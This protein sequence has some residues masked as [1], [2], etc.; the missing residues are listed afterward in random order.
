MSSLVIG[1]IVFVA[2]LFGA[3]FGMWLRRRLP[4]HH[5][6]DQTRDT[7]NLGIGLVATMSAIILGLMI[8]STKNTFDSMDSSVREAAVDILTLDRT[9]ARYGAETSVLRHGLKSAVERHLAMIGS[10][11]AYEVTIHDPT[12]LAREI[13]E[14]SNAIGM[15]T[16]SDPI[17]VA[18]Q[19]RAQDLSEDLMESRW[20]ASTGSGS[21]VPAPFL[22]V[23]IFW[24]TITLA[25]F[26]L[27]APRNQTIIAVF[28]VCSLSVGSAIFLMLEL[29]EPFAGLIIVSPE[30]LTYA[31]S[32]L[33]D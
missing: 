29:S 22:I 21:S 17:H 10:E 25:S 7:V 8:D 32:H 6:G 31:L 4:E 28:V 3:L 9:L 20:F 27:F 19:S 33:G 5:F 2:T 15:L 12:R 11:G 1:I 23:L 26:G 13:E 18:L 14:I 30:P 16:P 24:L